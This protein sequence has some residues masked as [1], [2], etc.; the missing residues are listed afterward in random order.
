MYSSKQKI[1]YFLSF[2]AFSYDILHSS[3]W[4]FI[5]Y[6]CHLTL[7]SMTNKTRY[8]TEITPIMTI[9]ILDISPFMYW[10]HIF[11]KRPFIK[12]FQDIWQFP[13]LIWQII[14]MTH[15]ICTYDKLSIIRFWING[16][17]KEFV[18]KYTPYM[19]NT[20]LWHIYDGFHTT[21]FF[22]Q[23]GFSNCDRFHTYIYDSFYTK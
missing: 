21:I 7:Q 5:Y 12:G 3:L 14:H 10:Y 17:F 20:T 18:T 19:T 15:F 23:N 13:H 6:K 1:R 8:M 4:Q 9:F 16:V 2:P 22:W 11:I